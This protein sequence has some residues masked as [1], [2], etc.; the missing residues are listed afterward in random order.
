MSENSVN[1]ANLQ[2]DEIAS[3][4]NIAENKKELYAL[5]IC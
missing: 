3:L 5:P 4:K 1:S 2:N